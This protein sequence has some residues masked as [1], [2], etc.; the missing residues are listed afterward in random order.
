MR[1]PLPKRALAGDGRLPASHLNFYIGN[2]TVLVPTF[3]GESD[4]AALKTLQDAFPTRGVAGIDC[5]ALVYGLG[6]I[7]CVTQQVP[8]P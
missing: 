6:T 3:K 4:R 2:G 5:R 8:G 7:H 1:I